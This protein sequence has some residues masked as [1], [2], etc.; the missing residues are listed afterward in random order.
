MGK[1]HHNRPYGALEYT[2]TTFNLK[3]KVASKGG[4]SVYGLGQRWPVTLYRDQWT[5]LAE[6]MPNILAF[7]DSKADE[8]DAKAKANTDSTRGSVDDTGRITL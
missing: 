3:A 7:A 2:I 5:A 6:A 8:C 1:S 4:I